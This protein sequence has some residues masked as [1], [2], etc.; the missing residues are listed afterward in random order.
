[1]VYWCPLPW[2]ILCTGRDIYIC[3]STYNTISM[4]YWCSPPWVIPYTGRDVYIC[5]ST[6]NTIVWCI[7]VLLY[8]I[9]QIQTRIYT[10][11]GI[12]KYLYTHYH[13]QGMLYK[14]RL[15][16]ILGKI[17]NAI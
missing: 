7:G 6:Y 5:Y 10:Y 14:E 17:R 1:M 11:M 16:E 3:Y 4:V 2:V 13:V 9:I 15:V 12:Y 8:G